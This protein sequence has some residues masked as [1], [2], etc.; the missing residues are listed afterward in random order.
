MTDGNGFNSRYPY[1]FLMFYV[2]Y[3]AGYAIYN[4]FISVYL[5]S[6][7]FSRIIVGALLALG[8]FMAIIGQPVWGMACDRAR[9][10]NTIL[11]LLI[12]GSGIVIITY[13][14]YDNL[15][16]LI[17]VIAVFSFFQT[18]VV[19]V[20]DTITLEYL[21]NTRWKFGPI[22]MGGTIGFAL[23]SAAAGVILRKNI[24]NM[25]MIYFVI[26]MLTLF[27]TFRLAHVKGHQSYG[28]RMAAWKL[29]ENGEFVL[30]LGFSLI[31][32]TTLGFY[33]SFFPIYFMEM[34]GTSVMLGIVMFISAMSEIPFL[35]NA[36]KIINR[37]GIEY[38][39]I[40][41]AVITALRWLLLYLVENPYLVL[42]LN[43]L[44]GL[45]FIV[46]T[47]CMVMYIS[48][49]VPRELMTSGQ[50]MHGLVIMGLSRILGSVIGGFLSDLTGIREVFLY[51]SI[52]NF[53]SVVIFGGLF[54]IIRHDL[55]GT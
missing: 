1:R 40:G 41:S 33:Y 26:S 22:R 52:I 51:I 34:G 50:T 13:P 35:L 7:S 47:Y 8:P 11:K 48:K 29:F 49:N 31:Y 37:I 27:I 21:E 5:N 16:Y 17:G 38:T 30:L 14:L 25:F 19:P 55:K 20:G 42:P 39:M 6:L 9:Y 24:S 18:S 53:I 12:T 15:Y 44:H 43:S 3:Y 28:N 2:L 45:G 32:H 46:F 54:I 10:K 4:T 23:T 36:E